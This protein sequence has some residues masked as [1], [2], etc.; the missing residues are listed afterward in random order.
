[1]HGGPAHHDA[2]HLCA[3][4][5]AWLRLVLNCV[6][7]YRFFGEPVVKACAECGTDYLDI[8]GEPGDSRPAPPRLAAG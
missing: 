7:P 6:G 3:A 2:N 8:C 1:V 5:S 4:A